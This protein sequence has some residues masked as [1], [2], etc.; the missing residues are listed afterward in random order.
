MFASFT[1]ASGGLTV[2]KRAVVAG[3]LSDSFSYRAGYAVSDRDF[4]LDRPGRSFMGDLHRERRLRIP[5]AR[6]RPDPVDDHAVQ[7]R[8][9][10]SRR[11]HLPERRAAARERA[12]GT[13]LRLTAT[14]TVQ[15][16]MEMSD[17][18]DAEWEYS[19]LVDWEWLLS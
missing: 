8:V 7:V 4:M 15:V 3:G 18:S 1:V 14:Q 17:D 10:G 19:K 9:H 12:D 2:T 16:L 6:W 11:G 5:V 13:K